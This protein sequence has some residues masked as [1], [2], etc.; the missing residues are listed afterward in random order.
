MGD[1]DMEIPEMRPSR[2]RLRL[3]YDKTTGL[4][5]IS[6]WLIGFV[7]FK[8]LPIL[9]SLGISFTDFHMLKPEDTSFVGLAN[10]SRLL[11][12]PAIGYLIAATINSAI[13]TVPLQLGAS[14]FLAWLLSFSWRF[15]INL[16]AFWVPD[17]IGFARL[18]F[19]LSWFLSRF[20]VPLRFLPEW[21]VQLCYLTPFPHMI[22][23]PV[24]IYL[25]LLSG[26]DF[27]HALPAQVV[28]IVILVILG[29]FVMRAGVRR[30][31]IQGG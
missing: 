8:L 15:L 5:L 11:K 22:N 13:R 31:V 25:G 24:E 12:D 2:F 19:A 21:F 16:P 20:L 7:L 29:Q 18:F 10:Y 17:A 23:T 28:W 27:A 30:L 4:L 1:D 26:S 6:P 9:A 3:R 14:I